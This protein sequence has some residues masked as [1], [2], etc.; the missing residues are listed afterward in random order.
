[1]GADLLKV[2]YIFYVPLLYLIDVSIVEIIQSLGLV[3]TLMHFFKQVL[4]DVPM[5]KVGVRDDLLGKA[6]LLV[7]S[8]AALIELR[9]LH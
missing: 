1:M 4:Q 9:L 6:Q 7:R 2:V 3:F 8:L 5:H